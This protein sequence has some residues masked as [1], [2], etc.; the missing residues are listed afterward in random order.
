MRGQAIQNVRET[1]TH[2]K[3]DEFEHTSLKR[4]PKALSFVLIRLKRVSKK[5]KIFIAR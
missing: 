5:P 3:V 4:V 2:M 1:V